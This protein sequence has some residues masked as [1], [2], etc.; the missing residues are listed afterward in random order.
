MIYVVEEKEL[1]GR[2]SHKPDGVPTIAQLTH[3]LYL[4]REGEMIELRMAGK[5]YEIEPSYYIITG[6][7]HQ[8]YQDYHED[9]DVYLIVKPYETH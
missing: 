3:A 8:L 5:Y 2:F 9:R 1:Y 6:V 4:P 7:L